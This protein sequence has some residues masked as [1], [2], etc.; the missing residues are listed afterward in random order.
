MPQKRIVL[1]L[2][3]G[4][5]KAIGLPLT[6]EILPEILRRLREDAG[7][8]DKRNPLGY[9]KD[10]DLKKLFALLTPG[11]FETSPG[12]IPLITDVLSIIDHISFQ[13][14]TLWPN[15]RK[16]NDIAYFRELLEEAIF[17]MI[18]SSKINHE[19]LSSFLKWIIKKS[20]TN[21]LTI[22]SSNYDIALDNKIFS[23]YERK[24]Y[25]DKGVEINYERDAV[26]QK[27]DFGINWRDPLT[28]K[29]IIHER[30]KDPDYRL[31]KLH[32]SLNWLKCSLCDHIYINVYGSIQHLA[33]LKEITNINTCH[34][35]NA[36][37]KAVLIAPSFVRVINDANLLNIW[38]NSLEELRTADEW[39][40][41]GYSFPPED[42]SIKSMFLR[43][44]NGR[45]NKPK[46]TVVQKSNKNIHNYKLY[47]EKV[48]SVSGGIE[49]YIRTN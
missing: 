22:I 18:R 31:F 40:I 9:K 7:L 1:F 42:L 17:Q 19:Q 25:N 39:V 6:A 33:Y 44:Y 38:K 48:E 14:N 43:A 29:P 24:I 2:G 13:S 23:T 45:D 21:R 11:I 8:F 26:A 36:P 3:A 46:I 20:K 34:C 35:L 41:M 47:F 27:V 12:D 5:S 32:G 15:K 30:P 49:E 28:K 16:V 37:L 10:T 4:S